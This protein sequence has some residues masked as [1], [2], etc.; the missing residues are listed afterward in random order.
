M[1]MPFD[2]GERIR[3]EWR[4]FWSVM[5]LVILAIVCEVAVWTDFYQ[6]W[7]GFTL[8]LAYTVAVVLAFRF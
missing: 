3:S 4:M 8:W 7:A 1:K 2:Y 6:W 5:S